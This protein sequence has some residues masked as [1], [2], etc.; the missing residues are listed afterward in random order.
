MIFYKSV[1][2]CLI[3]ALII[4]FHILAAFLKK[5]LSAVVAYVNIALHI[6]LA[7]LL[8]FSSATLTE[9]ALIFM[10]SLLVFLA[11]NLLSHK[12]AG[13]EGP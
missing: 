4:A 1:W 13:G 11:A 6:G 2:A 10:G 12:Y 7:V 9:L 3:I 8:Y 5:P